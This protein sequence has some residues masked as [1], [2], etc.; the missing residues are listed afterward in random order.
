M[1]KYKINSTG[2]CVSEC[3][4]LSLYKKYTFQYNDFSD[5]DYDPTIQQYILEEEIPPKYLFGNLCL[6]ECPL[7]TELN[8]INNT[9]ICTDSSLQDEET[10]PFLLQREDLRGR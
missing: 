8:E 1:K 9:C 5:Y 10:A 4:T 2:E 3:P 6:E 7:G